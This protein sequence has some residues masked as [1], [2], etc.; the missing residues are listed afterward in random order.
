MAAL[1][2]SS[3]VAPPDAVGVGMFIWRCVL[4]TL[5]DVVDIGELCRGTAAGANAWL[6]PKSVSRAS[7]VF[8]GV[9]GSRI[10]I[11]S[12]LDIVVVTCVVG[13]SH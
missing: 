9:V 1:L 8:M 6:P 10:M 7:S 2:I 4:G 3:G 13:V 12:C 5:R 11:V